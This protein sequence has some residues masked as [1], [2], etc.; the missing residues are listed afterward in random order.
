MFLK[1]NHVIPFSKR[2][3]ERSKRE[4]CSN[5]TELIPHCIDPK[6]EML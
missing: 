4:T 6:L 2:Q 5:C 3:N 1:L